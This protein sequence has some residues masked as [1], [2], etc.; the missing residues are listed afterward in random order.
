M[1]AGI[2]GLSSP[3]AEKQHAADTVDPERIVPNRDGSVPSGTR[4]DSTRD[5]DIVKGG[6]GVIFS[7]LGTF[8]S[9]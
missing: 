3:R 2:M 5:G 4:G 6:R 1:S 7:F 8:L 9:R